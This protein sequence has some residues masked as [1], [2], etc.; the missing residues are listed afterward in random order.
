MKDAHDHHQH[1][2]MTI[3]PEQEEEV[4]DREE[5]QEDEEDSLEPSSTNICARLFSALLCIFPKVEPLPWGTFA[6]LTVWS[7]IP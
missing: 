6:I 7:A 3:T 1:Q 5:I 2:K 4:E